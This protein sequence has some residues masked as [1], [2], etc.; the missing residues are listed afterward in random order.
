M[1]KRHLHQ[2]LAQAIERQVAAIVEVRGDQLIAEWIVEAIG[3][4]QKQITGAQIVMRGFKGAL[5][6]LFESQGTRD[7]M[8]VNEV[9]LLGQLGAAFEQFVIEGV[10]FG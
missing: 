7:D 3:A 4:Q 10:I 1:C 2:G 5:I 8:L 9:C 6:L